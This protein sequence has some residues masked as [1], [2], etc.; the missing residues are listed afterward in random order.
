MNWKPGDRAI[1]YGLTI[2]VSLNGEIVYITSRPYIA[3]S[4]LIAVDIEELDG[5]WNS[6][7]VVHIKPIPYDGNEV[8]SWEKC[9]WQPKEVVLQ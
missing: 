9:V 1:I 2:D 3:V 5:W 8:T 7:D 4:G 6:I